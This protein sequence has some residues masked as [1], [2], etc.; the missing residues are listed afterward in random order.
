[1]TKALNI[2][3]KDFPRNY[4]RK[5]KYASFMNCASYACRMTPFFD[6]VIEVEAWEAQEIGDIDNCYIRPI[7]NWQQVID[8]RNSE[9]TDFVVPISQ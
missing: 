1:M 7:S 3:V 5:V 4:D 8:R 2:Q 9:N 6:T